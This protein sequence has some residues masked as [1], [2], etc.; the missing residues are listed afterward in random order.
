MLYVWELAREELRSHYPGLSILG[1]FLKRVCAGSA[2][3]PFSANYRCR[4]YGGAVNLSQP[5]MWR[6]AK[7]PVVRDRMNSNK[8]P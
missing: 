6:Q 7:S 8:L 1:K 3:Q 2:A 5:L 4:Q